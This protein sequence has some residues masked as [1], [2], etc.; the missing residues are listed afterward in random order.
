M[1]ESY[2]FTV[3]TYRTWLTDTCCYGQQ[4]HECDFWR[5]C[6]VNDAVTSH[7]ST[8]VAVG[9][10]VNDAVTTHLTTVVSVGCAPGQL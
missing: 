3:K 7:L 9:C 8:V 6:D 5:I 1:R 10:D 4:V 2:V